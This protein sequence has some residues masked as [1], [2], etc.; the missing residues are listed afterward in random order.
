M[1]REIWSCGNS[2]QKPCLRS[3]NLAKFSVDSPSTVLKTLQKRLPSIGE[4]MHRAGC[5]AKRES[6]ADLLADSRLTYAGMLGGGIDTSLLQLASN[7]VGW[8]PRLCCHL[9]PRGREPIRLRLR[10]QSSRSS[11]VADLP[12]LSWCASACPKPRTRRPRLG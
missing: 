9:H 1:M 5:H 4:R 3:E 10:R 8:M 6:L 7:G 2:G 11:R 12:S